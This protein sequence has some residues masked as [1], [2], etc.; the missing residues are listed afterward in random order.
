MRWRALPELDL[1][2]MGGLKCLLFGAGTLGSNVAR[3]LLVSSP[4]SLEAVWWA[5]WGWTGQGW[6]VR[7]LTFV[8]NGRVSYS[9]PARQS[10]YTH[11]DCLQVDPL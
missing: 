8:D 4:S 3:A 7:K 2:A 5:A 1:E 9:N 6:G 11:E 10:L